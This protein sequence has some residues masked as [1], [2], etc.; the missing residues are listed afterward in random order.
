MAKCHYAEWRWAQCRGAFYW[1]SLQGSRNKLNQIL[2]NDG[3]SVLQNFSIV[4]K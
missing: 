2:E 4:S 1:D 3:D